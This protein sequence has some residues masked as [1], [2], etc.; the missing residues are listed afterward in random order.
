LLVVERHVFRV[1]GSVVLNPKGLPPV[2]QKL[3]YKSETKP[4]VSASGA[5]L[6]FQTSSIP[7]QGPN[8]GRIVIDRIIAHVSSDTSVATAALL[9]QDFY[10]YFRLITVKQKDGELRVQE[11]PGDAMR[12]ALYEM[13]GANETKEHADSGTTNN[14]TLIATCVIPMAKPFAHT[15]EDYSLAAELLDYVEIGC[16][17]SAEMSLGS[18]VVTVNSAN[19]WLIFE[20][21]EEMD[22]IQHAVDL[23]AV[24]DFESTTSQECRLNVHGRLQDLMLFVRGANGGASLAN[25]TSGGIKQPVGMADTTLVRNPDLIE[26]YARSRKIVTGAAA[27]TGNPVRSDPFVASTTRA[28][29]LLMT[30]GNSCGDQPEIDTVVVSTVHTL[31]ATLTAVMRIGKPRQD[32]TRLSIARKYGLPGTYR[33]KTDKKSKRDPAQWPPELR[34]YMPIKF[35]KDPS[36]FR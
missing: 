27:T 10:R 19:Y 30:E 20:C 35:L 6:Q 21:H 33:M 25:F 2:A 32:K 22:V 9:G 28:V 29:A 16:A 17:S 26:R 15:P 14:Q 36:A 34:Q 4:W 12:V 31:G 13:I 11:V 23:I 18:S 7:K 8:K 1:T 5:R 24:Q 3:V